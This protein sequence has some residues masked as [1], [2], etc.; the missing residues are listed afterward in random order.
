MK[1]TIIAILVTASLAGCA[2][3]MH[4]RGETAQTQNLTPVYIED[5][6]IIDVL[7]VT[8][9]GSKSNTPKI[10]GA[11]GGAAIGGLLGH[12]V[13]KGN[14]KKWATAVGALAGGALGASAADSAAAQA[15]AP[16]YEITVKRRTGELQRL[17]QPQ[18]VDR[19]V[20][21]QPARLTQ[22]SDGIWHVSPLPSVPNPALM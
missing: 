14:G 10:A 6:T 13:G 15:T 16:G 5:V 20:P 11:I 7:P 22:S 19:F 21:G 18:S 12:Q 4:Q 1:K 9:T 17:V 2:I 8:M 3:D